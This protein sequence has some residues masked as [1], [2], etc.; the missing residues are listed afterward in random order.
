MYNGGNCAIPMQFEVYEEK[1]TSKCTETSEEVWAKRKPKQG[2]VGK[3]TGI[4]LQAG[5]DLRI[6]YSLG[7]HAF[8]GPVQLFPM[9]TQY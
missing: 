5:T 9:I 6:G 1:E 3:T 8:G 7:P 4:Y 2:A